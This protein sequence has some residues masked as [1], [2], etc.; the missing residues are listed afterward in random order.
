M[1][2]L[3]ATITVEWGYESHS[4]TLTPRNWAKI[5]SGAPHRQRGK[6]YYCGPEF[7][8]DYW[9]F[10]GGMDG[11]L[12]VDYG[13]DGGQ[14]FVGKLRA[15]EIQEHRPKKKSRGRTAK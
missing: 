15:T 11:D 3:A 6:G 1:S 4:I 9:V 13:N 2:M 8:W 7:F 10:G 12:T 14:G 5:K